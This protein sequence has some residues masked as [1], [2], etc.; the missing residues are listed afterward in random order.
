MSEWQAKG[1]FDAATK[2]T[3]PAKHRVCGFG[4]MHDQGAEGL[5]WINWGDLRVA[6][7]TMPFIEITHTQY[8]LGYVQ[9]TLSIE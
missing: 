6:I 4:V 7:V 8:L 1:G 3:G 2:A 5:R 9:L